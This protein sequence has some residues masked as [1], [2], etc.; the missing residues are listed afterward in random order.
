MSLSKNSNM[1]ALIMSAAHVLIDDTAEYMRAIDTSNTVISKKL[2]KRIRRRIRQN[3]TENYWSMVPVGMKKAIA[4]VLVFCT[5][6][7][8]TCMSVE[9]VR[10]DMWN[11]ILKWYDKFVTVFFVTDATT[12]N[13][14]V[15]F[16]EPTLQLAG[17]ERI[18]EMQT[19][20]LN[21]IK[22]MFDDELGMLFLQT[23]LT[24]QSVDLDAENS[25]ISET[26]RIGNADGT[27]FIYEDGRKT[28]NWH[29]DEYIYS[30]YVYH[31]N[32]DTAS[33]IQ[34]AASVK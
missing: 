18:V 30:I 34:I 3:T 25:C 6:S 20:T 31:P 16:R 5:I 17:T 9:A 21:Q 28:I 4:A 12:P 1:D 11:T 33:M 26:I 22:Y 29:D 2:D 10:E 15:D 19:N 27:I 32:I 23:P 14:I 13:V 24:N 7:F 8:A